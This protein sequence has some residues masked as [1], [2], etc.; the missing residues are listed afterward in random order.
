MV[1]TRENISQRTIKG[2]KHRLPKFGNAPLKIQIFGVVSCSVRKIEKYAPRSP[3]GYPA[4]IP[5]GTTKLRVAPFFLVLNPVRS[6]QICLAR[7]VAQRPARRDRR[8]RFR[9][10]S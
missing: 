9:W 2:G 6:A 3:K 5:R 4:L 1:L 8:R 10:V 7:L